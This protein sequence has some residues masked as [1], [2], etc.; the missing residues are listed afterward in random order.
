MWWALKP[1]EFNGR[2]KI[3]I[4]L[5]ILVEEKIVS[6][7]TGPRFSSISFLF[8]IMLRFL[9]ILKS[10]Q[11]IVVVPTTEPLQKLFT[12]LGQVHPMPLTYPVLL[13]NLLLSSPTPIH[14]KDSASLSFPSRKCSCHLLLCA[15]VLGHSPCLSNC[16]INF[17]FVALLP[18][19]A[20]SKKMS[21]SSSIF[22]SAEYVIDTK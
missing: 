3:S 7:A 18:I 5:G 16:I 15:H 21:C 4:N 19:T 20:L 8:L 14:P 2:L 6:V 17:L 9:C 10:L 13:R 12:H 1:N 22:H 11:L